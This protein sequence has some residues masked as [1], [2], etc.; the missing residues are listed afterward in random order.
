MIQ[1]PLGSLS[2]SR[3]DWN[4]EGLKI[5]TANNIGPDNNFTVIYS[6]NNNSSDGSPL[7]V[8]QILAW[9]S[10]SRQLMVAW[11]AY[12][13]AGANN[14]TDIMLK[15][16]APTIDGYLNQGDN[17]STG[18]PVAGLVFIADGKTPLGNF[19]APLFIL[20]VN[21]RL[22]VLQYAPIGLFTGNTFSTITFI[23]GKYSTAR[24]QANSVRKR[25][26]VA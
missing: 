21:W 20:P 18:N 24:L 9:L 17:T 2:R 12:G 5:S 26:K 6:L 11:P 10:D 19:D 25:S 23:Y 1:T 3:R 14:G 22:A 7:A 8:Y 13:L 16:D 15:A 4:V